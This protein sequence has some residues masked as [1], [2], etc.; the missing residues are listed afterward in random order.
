MDRA[1]L[2]G[3]TALRIS[4]SGKTTKSTVKGP[5][6]GETGTHIQASGGRISATGEEK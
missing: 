2:P 3:K 4:G 5:C 1:K 6:S